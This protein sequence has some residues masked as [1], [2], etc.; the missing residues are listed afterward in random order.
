MSARVQ[1]I[2]HSSYQL[3][4]TECHSESILHL[5]YSLVEI[6]VTMVELITSAN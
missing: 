2:L 6:L 5:T 3:V 4:V 1:E